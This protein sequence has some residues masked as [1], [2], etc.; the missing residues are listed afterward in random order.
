[1]LQGQKAVDRRS[2]W[3]IFSVGRFRVILVG[4]WIPSTPKEK[5]ISEENETLYVIWIGLKLR[6]HK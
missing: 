6:C 4:L 5:N 1:M 3:T 2:W